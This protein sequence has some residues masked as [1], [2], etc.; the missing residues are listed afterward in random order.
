SILPDELPAPFRASAEAIAHHSVDPDVGRN[1]ATPTLADRSGAWHYVHVEDGDR[2]AGAME[3]KLVELT[4]RLAVT[5][6]E[7]RRR[8]DDPDL[9]AS[10]RLIAGWLAH[11]AADLAQP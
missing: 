11:Y 7:L 2:R 1:P 10:S 6:A 8:P 9:R 5:F 4:E 3:E